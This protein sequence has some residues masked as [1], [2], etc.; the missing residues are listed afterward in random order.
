LGR[1]VSHPQLVISGSLVVMLLAAAVLP[2]FGSQLMPP[3]REGH[4]VV[5]SV[6]SPGT[7][8]PAM[9]AI[10]A[11]MSQDLLAVPGVVS[12]EQT[13]G[14]AES[15]EDTWEPNRSEFHIELARMSGHDEARTQE[16]IRDVAERYPSLRS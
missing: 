16:G 15:G 10:G 5:Q 14:R 6:A 11:R 2:L 3:F 4:F 13:I 9:K 12:V 8:L 7:S 1:W